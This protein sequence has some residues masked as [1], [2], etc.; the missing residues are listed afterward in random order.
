M[1]WLLGTN[2]KTVDDC[3]GVDQMQ[4][5]AADYAKALE[6]R[7]QNE[8]ANTNPNVATSAATATYHSPETLL[9]RTQS[10]VGQAST[11]PHLQTFSFDDE[12]VKRCG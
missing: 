6:I 5:L 3:C 4:K 1:S 10:S 9:L 8:A 12:N 7:A 2:K 11:P